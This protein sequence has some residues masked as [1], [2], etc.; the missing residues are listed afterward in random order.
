MTDTQDTVKV[1]ITQRDG[2][3][4]CPEEDAH[5]NH[6]IQAPHQNMLPGFSGAANNWYMNM[7][8]QTTSACT[9]S[10]KRLRLGRTATDGE[11][12]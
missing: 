10:V 5:G 7:L 1:D 4:R 2:Y 9:K 8:I 6:C 3:T 11:G 12:S